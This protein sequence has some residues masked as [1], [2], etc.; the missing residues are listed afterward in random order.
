MCIP[1]AR[2][3]H[4]ELSGLELMDVC[5][6][7]PPNP[8]GT[9]WVWVLLHQSSPVIRDEAVPSLTPAFR[10]RPGGG[11]GSSFRLPCA[12]S[13]RGGHRFSLISGRTQLQ[14]WK[15]GLAG[16]L[17]GQGNRS[18]DQLVSLRYNSCRWKRSGG[19]A[20]GQ[21]RMR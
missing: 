4:P 18:G 9:R 3:R 14:G 6:S 17:G 8:V 16:C 12:G 5:W 20:E 11:R 7:F 15:G 10:N 19:R 13:G 1:A 21:L 2:K